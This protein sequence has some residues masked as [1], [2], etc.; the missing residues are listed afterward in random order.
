MDIKKTF[1]EMSLL[2]PLLFIYTLTYFGMMVA[3]F[4]LRQAF[5]MPSG[6][7]VVYIALVGAYAADKEI[8][9]W[10]GSE[11]PPKMGSVFVYLWLLFFLVAFVIQSVN[12]TFTMPAD[13]TAVALQVLAVFFGSKASKKIYELKSGSG[14]IAKSREEIVLQ[15]IKGRGK[16]TRKDVMESLKLSDSSVGRILADMEK[17]GRIQQV[18]DH[19]GAYYILPRQ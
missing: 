18:G 7:M 5:E 17:R 13:L 14:E 4:G 19:H 2:S 11:L 1:N 16:I 9:R 15:L 8:R 12:A 3:D 10:M 6:M